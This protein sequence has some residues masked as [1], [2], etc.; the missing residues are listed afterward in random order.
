MSVFPVLLVGGLLVGGLLAV[1]GLV[2]IVV[3]AAATGADS[4]EA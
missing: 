3:R 4:K 1:A 2:V